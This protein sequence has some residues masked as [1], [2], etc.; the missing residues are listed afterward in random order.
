M[1]GLA[2]FV[3][4]DGV[5]A[6]ALLETVGRMCAAIAHRGPD[7]AGEWIDVS[8]GVAIGFRRLAILD[9]SPAGHQPMQSASGRYVATLNGEIYNFEDLRRTLQ[10]SGCAPAFRGHSDTEVMLAAFDAWGIAGA[11]PRFNGMFA[12]AIWDRDLRRLYLVRDRAGVKP[13]YYG[14]AGRTFLYGSELK[15]LR[16]HPHFRGTI[17]RGALQLYVRF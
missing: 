17:D 3:S 11:V 14:F 10:Q 4:A 6:D 13:L 5:T 1:C 8:R 2:G 9:V 7:D 15:A 16:Q 12:I